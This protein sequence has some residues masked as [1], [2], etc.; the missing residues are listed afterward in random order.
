MFI[1][2]YIMQVLE[3]GLNA[4]VLAGYLFIVILV[5]SIVLSLLTQGSVN[6]EGSNYCIRRDMIPLPPEVKKKYN[7]FQQVW[8]WIL[9]L[10]AA[11]ATLY[12]VF[13]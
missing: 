7:P 4:Y 11:Y 8:V 3:I 10:V 9:V 12:I 1:M 6:P 2:P 13:W 5:L